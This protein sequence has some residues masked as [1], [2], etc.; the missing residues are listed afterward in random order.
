MET[1]TIGIIGAGNRGEEHIRKYRGVDGATVKA[2]ADIDTEAAGELADEF[3]IPD[4]YEDF[5]AMLDDPEIDVVNVCVHNNLHEPMAV[6]AFEADKH[7]FCEKPLAG[8]YTDAENI[9]DAANAADKLLAVQN[10]ELL[11]PETQAART[12]VESGDLGEVSFAR[13]V[14][15]RRRG[16]PYVD[17]YGTPAF[18][19]KESAG[20][21]PVFDI[22]TYEIGRNLYLLGNP[23]V[24]RV[25]GQTFD[26]TDDSLGEELTGDN[27]ELYRKRLEESGHDVEDAGTGAARLADGSRLE[28][29]A[30][31]HAY[32][33]DER[34]VVVGSQGGIAFDPVELLTTMNDY[35]TTVEIDVDGFETRHGLIR[36]ESGYEVDERP[37]QYDHFVAAVRGEV[38]QIRTDEIALNSMLVMEG[39][40]LSA[41]RGRE[42][43]A[44]EIAEASVSRSIDL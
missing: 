27:A 1:V 14:Y 22:G 33:P 31:W 42:V 13:S 32:Q 4:V 40:Y 23:A 5:E 35:E 43:T 18:V 20:G 12:F 29:R 9:V 41:E 24:E 19:S 26:Y 3:G 34:G 39:I 15:S 25:N 38:D 30:A 21:G 44:E 11:T 7:V 28:V 6:A 2:I 10:V 36:G 17:G 16:R 8:S 37:N